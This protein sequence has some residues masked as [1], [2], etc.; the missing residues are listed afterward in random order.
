M[1]ITYTMIGADGLQYG[2]IDLNQLQTWINEGRITGD[3]KVLRND[4]NTWQPASN[5]SELGLSPVPAMALPAQGPAVMTASPPV[6]PAVAAPAMDPMLE[7]RVRAGAS[8]FFAI[9]IF[10]VVNALIALSHSGAFFLV[11][12]GVNLLIHNLAVNFIIAGIFALFGVFARKAQTWSFIVGILLYALDGLLFL[13]TGLW[14]PLLFHGY[15]L[16]R[17][18]MGLMACHELNAQNR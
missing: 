11:G 17:I 3:T 7:R 2:P 15:V 5:Y 16:Y 1:E 13:S 12:L 4:T 14:L 10:S 9:G 18:C 8:W 6:R